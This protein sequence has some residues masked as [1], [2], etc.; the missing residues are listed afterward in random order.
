MRFGS[1]KQVDPERAQQDETP[2]RNPKRRLTQLTNSPVTPAFTRQLREILRK[3]A[4]D[5]W[6]D[7]NS[8][9]HAALEPR[10]STG[11]SQLNK[12][13]PIKSTLRQVTPKNPRP[14]RRVLFPASASNPGKQGDRLS[15]IQMECIQL[16]QENERLRTSLAQ[17]NHKKDELIAEIIKRDDYIEASQEHHQKVLDTI[18]ARHSAELARLQTK[19]ERLQEDFRK[20]QMEKTQ[21][22]ATIDALRDRHAHESQQLIVHAFCHKLLYFNFCFCA[23]H[24]RR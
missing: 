11:I 9:A 20:E 24:R 15:R 8:S 23:P 22:E 5:G 13:G 4:D 17:P 7:Q 16:K 10:E 6:V 21:L 18:K 12:S 19:A 14:L 2:K 1:L 3:D